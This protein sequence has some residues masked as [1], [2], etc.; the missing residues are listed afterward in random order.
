M[1]LLQRIMKSK[2]VIGQVLIAPNYLLEVVGC[3]PQ[4]DQSRSFDISQM[5]KHGTFFIRIINCDIHVI[6]RLQVSQD[7][8]D[9]TKMTAELY[10]YQTK[11]SLLEIWRA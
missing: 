10:F 8:S 2:F 6:L 7:M 5:I 4:G 3:K 11:Q 1:S 9:K